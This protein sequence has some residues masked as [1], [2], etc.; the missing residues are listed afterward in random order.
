[1][2]ET[3]AAEVG[4]DDV[5]KIIKQKIYVIRGAKSDAG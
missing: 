1:M 5:E 4:I 3:K 2:D